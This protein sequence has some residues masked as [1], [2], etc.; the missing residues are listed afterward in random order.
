[1]KSLTYITLFVLLMSSVAC[2]SQEKK[3]NNAQTSASADIEVYYFHYT[4]RCVTCMAVE[5]EAKANIENLYGG[6]VT[7]QSI[8]LD[9]D[10][11]TELA[12]KFGVDGQ[13]LIIIKGSQKIDITNEGFMYAR[14]NPAKFKT[15]IQDKIE[16]LLKS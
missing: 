1:M 13:T 7:F 11:S 6:K 9:E 3:E 12:K 8:N 10:T 14:S 5:S 16:S 2:N 15:I 4:K